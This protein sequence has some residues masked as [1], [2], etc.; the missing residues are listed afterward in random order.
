MRWPQ[1]II[2]VLYA[3]SLGIAAAKHGEPRENY[4]FWTTLFAVIIEA[5]LLYWGGFWG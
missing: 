1:I 5:L 4:S 3:A 2:I